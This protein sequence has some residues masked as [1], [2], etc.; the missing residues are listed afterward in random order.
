MEQS[1]ESDLSNQDQPQFNW[2]WDL[3]E[4]R[5]VTNDMDLVSKDQF[6]HL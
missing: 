3:R 4:Q 1:D 6:C 5:K 2:I